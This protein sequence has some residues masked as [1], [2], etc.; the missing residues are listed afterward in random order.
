MQS[1][2]LLMKCPYLL[3]LILNILSLHAMNHKQYEWRTIDEIT[4]SGPTSCIYDKD[5]KFVIGLTEH[6]FITQHYFLSNAP[7]I[8]FEYKSPVTYIAFSPAQ[9][10]LYGLSTKDPHCTKRLYTLWSLATK[11]ILHQLERPNFYYHLSP[12]DTYLITQENNIIEIRNAQ[13]GDILQKVCPAP[14]RQHLQADIYFDPSFNHQETFMGIAQKPPITHGADKADL[15]SIINLVTWHVHKLYGSQCAP[16]FSADGKYIATASESNTINVFSS[17]GFK[18]FEIIKESAH[19]LLFTPNNELLIK[20]PDT[21][22][23]IPTSLTAEYDMFI[24][25]QSITRTNPIFLSDTKIKLKHA[26]SNYNGNR[27]CFTKQQQHRDHHKT[28]H[29]LLYKILDTNTLK[30]ICVGN[31][32]TDALYPTPFYMSPTGKYLV[33]PCYKY[34]LIINQEETTHF[35]HT[36]SRPG[37]IHFSNDE[38]TIAYQPDK[39]TAVLLKKYT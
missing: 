23:Q 26:L 33:I 4:F 36:S 19:S 16:A 2:T 35:W 21:S 32:K 39:N 5:N 15:S 20:H 17:Q 8:F 6:K 3:C 11:K 29:I 30:T 24:S 27:I 9:K 37:N 25:K 31:C 34:E 38:K 22:L 12:R 18:L 10:Y 1:Q 14:E 28:Y 7:A 13:T